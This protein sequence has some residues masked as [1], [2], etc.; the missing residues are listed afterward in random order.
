MALNFTIWKMSTGVSIDTSTTA[1]TT[2]LRTTPSQQELVASP[3]SR[4]LLTMFPHSSSRTSLSSSPRP[5]PTHRRTL[6]SDQDTTLCILLTTRQVR[7]NSTSPSNLK[8]SQHQN[9]PQVQAHLSLS[10]TCR[11]PLLHLLH[12][13]HLLSQEVQFLPSNSNSK[14]SSLNPSNSRSHSSS[15]PSFQSLKCPADPSLRQCT[16][17]LPSLFSVDLARTH[18]GSRPDTETWAKWSARAAQGS[19]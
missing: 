17:R 3:N 5:E 12:L 13:L 1:W 10:W 11:F 4:L 9:C 14:S 7:P 2:R 16:M 18:A 15:N 6:L 19:S 8:S